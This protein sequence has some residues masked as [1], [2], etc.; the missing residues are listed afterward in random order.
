[1]KW[2]LDLWMAHG[3]S[4][5]AGVCILKNHFKVKIA[6]SDC[7]S[8]WPCNRNIKFNV[9]LLIF[10]VLINKKRTKNL[11]TKWKNKCLIY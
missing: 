3:A 2:G 8:N 6:C 1:M 11:Q 10:M 7:D 4:S 9:L 5:S